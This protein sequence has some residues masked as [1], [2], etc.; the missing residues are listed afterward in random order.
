MRE[1]QKRFNNVFF[2]KVNPEIIENIVGNR[3]KITEEKS[4]KNREVNISSISN[5]CFAIKLDKQPRQI[6]LLKEYTKV[7]DEL[8]LYLNNGK[9]I[10]FLIEL[11]SDC[12][13]TAYKQIKYGKDYASFLINILQNE[14]NY[15]F[16]DIEYRGYIFTTSSS[17]K[18][19]TGKKF[20][21]RC[22][23]KHG[24]YYKKF[25]ATDYYFDYLALPVEEM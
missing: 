1:I 19:T 15:T 16:S 23:K 2:E 4:N 11:K 14:M 24:I 17:T 8:L 10:V 21:H 7:N 3:L 25:P 18:R 12:I 20:K 9:L 22:V 6:Y 13:S 5:N